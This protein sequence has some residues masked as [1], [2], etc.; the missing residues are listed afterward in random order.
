MD[1][2]KS[3]N[4]EYAEISS[5]INNFMDDK[6]LRGNEP[7]VV[8]KL[9][10]SLKAKI[11]ESLM[12]INDSVEKYGYDHISIS[13]NGGK[14]CLVMLYLYMKI[15]NDKNLS[16]RIRSV[17]IYYEETFPKIEE[18]NQYMIDRYNLDL[19]IYSYCKLKEGFE[20]FLATNKDIKGILVGNRKTD[21]FSDKLKVFQDTDND[22]PNFVRIHPILNWNYTEVWYFLICLNL[23]YCSLY[24]NGY[25]SIGGKDTTILNPHLK[26]SCFDEDSNIDFS[27]KEWML[28]L[29]KDNV[30]D[31]LKAESPYYPAFCLQN[32]NFERFSRRKSQ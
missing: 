26:K 12:I 16:T 3:K 11:R 27:L 15:I 1:K 19:E 10:K 21:P 2:L 30:G 31:R 13:F 20:K 29:H 4:P 18:F 17:Y 5:R 32:D 8:L 23:E 22:W 7:E 9:R 24:D 14:D 25:T 6:D 28:L